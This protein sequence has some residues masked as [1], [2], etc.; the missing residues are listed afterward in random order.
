[1][2][3]SLLTTF[4]F[5]AGF[6]LVACQHA[7]MDV[8]EPEEPDNQV[9]LRFT[10]GDAEPLDNAAVSNAAPS[11]A[12]AI[13][14]LTTHLTLVLYQNG[15]QVK[16]LNQAKDDAGFGTME[17]SVDPGVYAYSVVAHN[18]E[19]NPTMTHPDKVTFPNNKTTDT[20]Y[21][22]GQ[23]NTADKNEVNVALKHAV[24]MFRLHTTDAIADSITAFVFKYTGGSSTLDVT[25][26][27]G[28][29]ESRQQ[30]TRTVAAD[31]R[32]N[33]GVFEV[34]TFPHADQDVLKMEV[35][36]ITAAGV[37]AYTRSFADVAV[38]RN[39]ITEYVGRFFETT[40]STPDNPHPS[41]GNKFTFVT[42]DTWEKVTTQ[43]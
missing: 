19:G 16:K 5:A 8:V 17:L 15:E 24:A 42:N 39:C 34:F 9:S 32:Q 23:I 29:V 6:G 25:S 27:H 37:V 38:K 30:E 40:P 18:G 28:S 36:A 33:G 2:K 4:F 3:Q 10:V 12:T 1:M 13:S 20:Y 7:P 31:M 43:F 26:G 11:R 35:Q 21:T 22:Y 14:D 41:A